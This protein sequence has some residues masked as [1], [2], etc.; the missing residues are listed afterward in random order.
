MPYHHPPIGMK[1]YRK[2]GHQVN[3]RYKGRAKVRRQLEI[4]LSPTSVRR[5][6]KEASTAITS[7]K[8]GQY[9]SYSNYSGVK[10]GH[11][12]ITVITAIKYER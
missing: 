7:I 8:R 12:A 2:E 3:P 5:Q 4:R 10:R 9:S 6:K 1:K 11:T